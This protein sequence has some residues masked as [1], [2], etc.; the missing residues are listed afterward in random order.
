MH[1]KSVRVAP[2]SPTSPTNKENS[3][4]GTPPR[5]KKIYSSK[6]AEDVLHPKDKGMIKGLKIKSSTLPSAFPSVI[7]LST[8]ALILF[9]AFQETEN[10]HYSG[11][12]LTFM[13]VI[14]YYPRS[15]QMLGNI[16][17][18]Q[19][20][21]IAKFSIIMNMFHTA[22]RVEKDLLKQ[23]DH[24]LAELITIL[25]PDVFAYESAIHAINSMTYTPNKEAC[26]ALHTAFTESRRQSTFQY[27]DN[28]SRLPLTPAEIY[29]LYD[30][31][32]VLLYKSQGIHVIT[33][34]TLVIHQLIHY[35]I[36]F[37]GWEKT[38][39][40][41]S[42]L[43]SIPTPYEHRE[44]ARDMKEIC[45]P[46]TS[47]MNRAMIKNWLI[48][49]KSSPVRRRETVKQASQ[50][51]NKQQFEAKED[52]RY[53]P[54]DILQ[55]LERSSELHAS[56][57]EKRIAYQQHITQTVSTLLLQTTSHA[58]DTEIAVLINRIARKEM[59]HVSAKLNSSF[60]SRLT[61]KRK[62]PFGYPEDRVVPAVFT[63]MYSNDVTDDSYEQTMNI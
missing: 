45:S 9:S 28:A 23:A 31:V 37:Y 8:P 32:P 15:T 6:C 17:V 18:D 41:E 58:T 49:T 27:M 57:E 38:A 24:V 43:A 47:D 16:P 4:N 56:S 40:L 35:P 50:L 2:A 51:M 54:S 44:I 19:Q 42:Y 25:R 48:E 60:E 30:L 34:K 62:N 29:E 59:L 22:F 53:Q 12:S 55:A 39:S 7:P 36:N 46:A 14:D 33:D 21:V 26:L 5:L 52:S 1:Q 63:V 3:E 61:N 10:Q 20:L 13:R 11:K